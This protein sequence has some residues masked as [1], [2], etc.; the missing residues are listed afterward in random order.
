MKLSTIAIGPNITEVLAENGLY[1]Y[2]GARKAEGLE[3]LEW[4]WK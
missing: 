2:A 4:Q 1:V 3:R